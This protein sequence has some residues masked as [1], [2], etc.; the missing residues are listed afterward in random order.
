[1]KWTPMAP[2][3]GPLTQG[4]PRTQPSLPATFT[5]RKRA[6]ATRTRLT[7]GEMLGRCAALLPPARLEA[8]ADLS[9]VA[10]ASA[11]LAPTISATSMVRTANRQPACVFEFGC[12]NKVCMGI[13]RSRHEHGI[14]RVAKPETWSREAIRQTT[15]RRCAIEENEV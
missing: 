12:R 13:L 5:S 9:S 11:L 7:R 15:F 10:C 6:V 4:V 14:D 3:F 2:E 8:I 1:M